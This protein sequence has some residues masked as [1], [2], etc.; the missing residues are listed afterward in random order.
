MK[1]FNG[2]CLRIVENSKLTIRN[3]HDCMMLIYLYRLFIPRLDIHIISL[4][5]IMHAM[6]WPNEKCK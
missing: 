1:K 4:I 2:I 3:I 6:I 5:L